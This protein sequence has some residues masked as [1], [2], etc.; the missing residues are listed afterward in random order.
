M[1]EAT[2][3]IETSEIIVDQYDDDNHN[4]E[5]DYEDYDDETSEDNE[6]EEI[7]EDIIHSQRQ[8]HQPEINDDDNCNEDGFE[9]E[10]F[11]DDASDNLNKIDHPQ[12]HLVEETKMLEDDHR[13][14]E[15]RVEE[16]A[17]LLFEK[18]LEDDRKIDQALADLEDQKISELQQ[19]ESDS[20]SFIMNH[21]IEM[22]RIE[23]E[24]KEIK[25]QFLVDETDFSRNSKMLDEKLTTAVTVLELERNNTDMGMKIDEKNPREEKSR[26]LFGFG[27]GRKKK[28][29]LDLEKERQL[30]LM[31]FKLKE[32]E[33]EKEVDDIKSKL[34]DTKKQA[35]EHE[36]KVAEWQA[37]L[38]DE[39]HHLDVI[40]C[41]TEIRLKEE[42]KQLNSSY[43]EEKRRLSLDKNDLLQTRRSNDEWLASAKKKLRD[44]YIVDQEQIERACIERKLI[45]LEGNECLKKIDS[46]LKAK[47]DE[48]ATA[49]IDENS[50]KNKAEDYD[51]ILNITDISSNED[52]SN[53]TNDDT[54][55][56]TTN[57]KSDII[58]DYDYDS[59]GEREGEIVLEEQNNDDYE[60][61]DD[62]ERESNEDS[63]NEMLNRVR[64]MLL[65]DENSDDDDDDDDILDSSSS[66]Y[67]DDDD[68][69]EDS[70]VVVEFD[71]ENIEGESQ[72]QKQQQ[73]Q[74]QQLQ[75][76]QQQSLQLQQ[77]QQQRKLKRQVLN[78]IHS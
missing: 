42:M 24:G 53:N 31:E 22:K 34:R 58:D 32:I 72:Q 9:S 43:E 30:K 11:W 39:S 60:E 37:E 41:A 29:D 47:W 4:E 3:P 77:Q 57:A 76:Q 2:I 13:I 46:V 7:S 15:A 71:V 54:N 62:I 45:N 51:E 68:D 14:A 49:L 64:N 8:K 35:T 78:R 5:E 69:D 74:F 18:W 40:A 44:K 52:V 56:Y 19:I 61:N 70:N 65:R 16:E 36:C 75:Q 63:K 25:A 1:N 33:L 26:G 38:D 17:S 6:E 20:S 50:K 73:Q 23:K 21:K 10:E 27:G 48:G 55:K 59:D 28:N 12:N 67:D 66:Y